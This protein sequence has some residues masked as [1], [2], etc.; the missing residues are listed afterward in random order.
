[1]TDA[2]IGVVLERSTRSVREQLG[3][4]MRH[5]PPVYYPPDAVEDPREALR[6]EIAAA[7]REAPTT[8]PYKGGW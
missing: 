7:H 6:A 1:M 4:T 5:L 8:P 2:D 3:R